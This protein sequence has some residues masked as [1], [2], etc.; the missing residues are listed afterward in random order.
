MRQQHG[1][2]QAQFAASLNVALST[3]GRWESWDPP[4]GIVLERLIK[5]AEFSKFPIATTLR[6]ELEKEQRLNLPDWCRPRSEDEKK[7]IETLIRVLR[8]PKHGEERQKLLR[9]LDSI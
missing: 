8:E 3:V 7:Y 2:T 5:W 1:I 6:H 9:I 4:K